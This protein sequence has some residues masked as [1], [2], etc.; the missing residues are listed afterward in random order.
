MRLPIL[1]AAL[2]ALTFVLPAAAQKVRVFGGNTQ[3]ACSSVLLF[4]EG[5]MAGITVTYGQPEWQAEYEQMLDRLKGKLNRLG[6][7]LW[8]TFLNSCDVEIGGTKIPAGS[9]VVG[10]SCDADGNFG[11]AFLDATKA[12][13]AG[14]M[15]FGPQTWKPDHVAP[16]ELRRDASKDAVAKMTMELKAEA[17]EP[18]RGT[19]TLS[20]GRHQ[21]VGALAIHAHAGK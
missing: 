21:L 18:T 20:W 14:T 5:V 9:W 13:Q 12:M 19:F 4:G 15:P 11:L 8:T 1:T 3:R 6:K 16:M 10:L 17:D 7:D 2:A